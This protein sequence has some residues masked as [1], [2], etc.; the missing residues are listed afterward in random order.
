MKITI[1]AGAGEGK[2]A[3]AAFLGEM[4]CQHGG[5]DV[6]VED[7]G[8]KKPFALAVGSDYNKYWN[9]LNALSLAG[10]GV[11]IVTVQ[12]NRG[13]IRE[14]QEPAQTSGGC[15]GD[16]PVSVKSGCSGDCSGGCSGSEEK[17]NED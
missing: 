12:T 15:C 16:K 4:L 14:P 8:E 1:S 6:T 3:M 9:T 17:A 10:K 5:F 7:E 11:D 2:S 13:P